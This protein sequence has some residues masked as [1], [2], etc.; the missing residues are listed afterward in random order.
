MNEE[1]TDELLLSIFFFF[2][3]EDGIRDWSVT[4]VQTCALPIY[5]TARGVDQRSP[6]RPLAPRPQRQSSRKH[7]AQLDA[8]GKPRWLRWHGRRLHLF[9]SGAHKYE[10]QEQY[11]RIE[12]L[13]RP[14]GRSH[15]SP[16]ERRTAAL[17]HGRHGGSR[18]YLQLPRRAGAHRPFQ[19]VPATGGASWRG[20]WSIGASEGHGRGGPDERL[21]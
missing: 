4:G 18:Q 11:P 15:L 12:G 13:Y 2:Q 5:S 3:A 16:A 9:P 1:I 17:V 7:L 8:S 10:S 6:A 14:F 21:A 20:R 19:A